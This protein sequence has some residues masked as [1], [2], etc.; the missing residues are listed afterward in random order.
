[1]AAVERA[2]PRCPH[3]VCA[4][5]NLANSNG[6]PEGAPSDKCEGAQGCP[7]MSRQS[8]KRNSGVALNIF[9]LLQWR[10]N[11]SNSCSSISF[12]F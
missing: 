8:R 5:S 2:D 3:L 9:S 1:M 11:P 10:F 4:L 6:N 7:V 12:P